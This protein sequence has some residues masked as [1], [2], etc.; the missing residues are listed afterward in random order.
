[1]F[2]PAVGAELV[3][4]LIKLYHCETWGSVWEVTQSLF[5]TISDIA[6]SIYF[7]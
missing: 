1:M 6:V 5:E 3:F 4:E 7:Y 2:S